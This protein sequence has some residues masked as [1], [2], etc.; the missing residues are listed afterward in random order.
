M[1]KISIKDIISL[2]NLIVAAVC[3]ITENIGHSGLITKQKY[4]TVIT[5]T[6]KAGGILHHSETQ[7]V[8][9]LKN[10]PIQLRKLQETA[11]KATKKTCIYTKLVPQN[12]QQNFLLSGNLLGNRGYVFV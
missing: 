8:L 6:E 11:A 4:L 7:K 1:Y 3:I 5:K 10:L 9:S 12:F 2:K